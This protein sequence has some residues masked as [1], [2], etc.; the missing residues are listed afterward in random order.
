MLTFYNMLGFLFS[1][2][3]VRGLRSVPGHV[4]G[5]NFKISDTK[6]KKKKSSRHLKNALYPFPNG[7]CH[8]CNNRL[9]I[10]NEIRMM[11]LP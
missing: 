4:G 7:C 6:V 1:K 2:L 11:D 3:K 5:W 10:L 8:S 9:L